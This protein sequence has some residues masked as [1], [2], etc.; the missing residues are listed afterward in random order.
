MI[1][2]K[3]QKYVPKQDIVESTI[4]PNGDIK[5]SNSQDMW[6]VLVGGDQLTAARIRGAQSIRINS[7]DALSK[8]RGV[9]PVVEDWHAR[10]TLL[11]V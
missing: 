2:E 6:E 1:I 5:R 3:M 11:K 9:H 8:L 4:L 10:L 7:H